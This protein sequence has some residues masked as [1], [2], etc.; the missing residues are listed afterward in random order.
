MSL[1]TKLSVRVSNGGKGK[2]KGP[3]NKGRENEGDYN[4]KRRLINGIL[5]TED[6][7][8]LRT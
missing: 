3:K 8:R 1:H 6:F 2:G 5:T 4:L 7:I